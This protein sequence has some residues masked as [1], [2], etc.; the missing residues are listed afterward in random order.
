MGVDVRVPATVA[1]LGPGFDCLGVAVGVHLEL[2]ISLAD[3]VEIVGGDPSISVEDDLT[4]RAFVSAFAAVGEEAPPVRIEVLGAFPQGRGLGASAAAIVGGLVGARAAGDLE[5]TDSELARLAIRMEGHADNVLPA[6]FGGLVLASA[7]GW[8]RFTP[9]SG[10]LPFVLVAP[11]RFVTAEA[12][13]ALPAEVPRADAVANAAATAT[14]V[15]VLSGLEPPAALMMA[16]ADRIHEPY[17]LP[18]LPETLDLH[19]GLRAQ[20]VAAALSGAGP[21]VVCL[22]ASGAI[23]DAVAVARTLLPEGW[24]VMVPGWDLQGAQ[25]R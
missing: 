15:A 22:S 5:V 1:N 10:V 9:A 6:M 21:S 4:H 16:T 24:E 18:L 17:R 12:R 23:E 20:G 2:N 7:D 11:G 14:L 19:Q 13:R 3:K 25:V 8:I